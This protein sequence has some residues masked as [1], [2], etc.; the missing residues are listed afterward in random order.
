MPL[1]T[2]T[3][4]RRTEGLPHASETELKNVEQGIPVPDPEGGEIHRCGDEPADRSSKDSCT[5]C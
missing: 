3:L 2:L 1:A 4:K 5:D